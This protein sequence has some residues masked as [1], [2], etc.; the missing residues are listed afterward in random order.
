MNGAF[1]QLPADAVFA[2]VGQRALRYAWRLKTFEHFTSCRC[3]NYL[4]H[5]QT[6]G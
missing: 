4:F 3:A 2:R 5:A 6:A 1:Q